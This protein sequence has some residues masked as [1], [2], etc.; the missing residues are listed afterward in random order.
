MQGTIA[1]F[2][3]N[4]QS[5]KKQALSSKQKA[6]TKP[7]DIITGL[8]LL[9]YMTDY[10]CLLWITSTIKLKPFE[11]IMSYFSCKVRQYILTSSTIINLNA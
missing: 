1:A 3:E 10:T 2:V 8:Y 4:T 5:G 6:Q 11:F 7:T 9:W